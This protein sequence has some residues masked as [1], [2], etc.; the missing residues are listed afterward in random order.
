MPK[1][2][3][4]TH[5]KKIRPQFLGIKFWI[6]DSKSSSRYSCWGFPVYSIEKLR[7]RFRENRCKRFFVSLW[8]CVKVF[9]NPNHEI[10]VQ[11]LTLKYISKTYTILKIISLNRI[12]HII[13]NIIY[14][15]NW[16]YKTCNLHAE[17]LNNIFSTPFKR[18]LVEERIKEVLHL[19]A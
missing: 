16:R 18:L 15:N 4:N 5:L 1:K 12:W 13:C 11:K 9:F 17:I 14:K 2:N 6:P 8:T 3:W 19:Q 10:S 7:K